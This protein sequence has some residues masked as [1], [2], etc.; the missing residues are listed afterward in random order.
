MTTALRRTTRGDLTHYNPDKGLKTIA[1]ADAAEKHFARAKDATKLRHAIRAKLKAQAEFVAWW[2][3]E[4]PGA[5]GP[6]QPKKNRSG[7]A[8]ILLRAGKDGL[9]ERFVVQR[10]RKHV[11]TPAALDAT[12]TAALA[13][14]HQDFRICR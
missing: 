10:W 11:G 3:A 6:G 8:T 12:E 2:D 5:I 1:V 14:V 9:P 4:G 7:S 13:E